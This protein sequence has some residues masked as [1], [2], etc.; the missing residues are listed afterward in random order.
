MHHPH[1]RNAVMTTTDVQ[2]HVPHIAAL[3]CLSFLIMFY[4][5]HH[6]YEAAWRLR[7]SAIPSPPSETPPAAHTILRV[8]K[9]NARK[10]NKTPCA[11]V[12]VLRTPKSASSALYSLFKLQSQN[13]PHVLFPVAQVLPPASYTLTAASLEN[14]PQARIDAYKQ[15]IA[16]MQY[17]EKLRQRLRAHQLLRITTIRAPLPRAQ[18][19]LAYEYARPKAV[20]QPALLYLTS[21]L[22]SR[23]LLTRH[24]AS[25]VALSQ[26]TDRVL[27][28]F[29]L[30]LVQEAFDVSL[31]L[32]MYLLNWRAVDVI[33]P[34][35]N[36]MPSSTKRKRI[37]QGR[38]ARLLT[39]HER[40][41]FRSNLDADEILYNRSVATLHR[42]FN[43][44]PPPYKHVPRV[45]SFLRSLMQSKCDVHNDQ[46]HFT[47]NDTKCIWDVRDKLMHFAKSNNISA[48]SS[49]Q[50]SL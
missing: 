32:L 17:T 47:T 12:L 42:N 34:R 41:V 38:A 10:N 29:H 5:I 33:A 25:N 48:L 45:L 50:N 1:V 8:L 37:V 28:D 13:C 20:L 14:V 35:L 40:C 15:F 16:H 2:P 46:K 9:L 18:S 27:Q 26:L 21:A 43:H 30:I 11:R 7:F 39:D 4:F 24:A 22:H 23:D 19:F 36:V 3:L 44:L 49:L 31:A 6:E